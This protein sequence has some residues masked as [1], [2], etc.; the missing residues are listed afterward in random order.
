MDIRPI[1]AG[2]VCDQAGNLY[3]TTEG[4]GAFGVG[5]V[6]KLDA[7]AKL[8]VLYSFRGGTDGAFLW[9]A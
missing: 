6:Y 1:T 3:G 9:R 7:A 2:V 8:T 4:G 5:A